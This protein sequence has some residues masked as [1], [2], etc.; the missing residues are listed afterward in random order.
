MLKMELIENRQERS[1]RSLQ[2]QE[3]QN[4]TSS[5]YEDFNNAI[6]GAKTTE[7]LDVIEKEYGAFVASS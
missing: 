5:Q 3:V 4:T 7:E 6:A 1:I 2:E